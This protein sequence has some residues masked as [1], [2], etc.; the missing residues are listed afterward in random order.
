MTAIEGSEMLAGLPD[1]GNRAPSLVG[2][3]GRD[4]DG[5]VRALFARLA[6]DGSSTT[7]TEPVR[8][9]LSPGGPTRRWNKTWKRIDHNAIVSRVSIEVDEADDCDVI[10]RVDSELIGHGV[11]PWIEHRRAGRRVDSAADAADRR[12][13]AAAMVRSISL[14]VTG[15]EAPIRP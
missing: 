13:F 2:W 14:V 5:P 7:V 8:A 9:V 11:P 12:E 1:L 4:L 15:E 6:T 3:V 10:A